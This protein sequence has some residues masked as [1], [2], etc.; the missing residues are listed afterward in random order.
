MRHA[1]FTELPDPIRATLLESFPALHEHAATAEVLWLAREDFP[2]VRL[3]D[4]A[5]QRVRVILSS[6]AWRFCHGQEEQEIQ[7]FEPV[8]VLR[9]EPPPAVAP[10]RRRARVRSLARA[11]LSLV[12]AGLIG[13]GLGLLTPRSWS[14]L[15]ATQRF[16]ELWQDEA[17]LLQLLERTPAAS[18]GELWELAAHHPSTRVREVAE[19]LRR[20]RRDR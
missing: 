17:A 19:R 5:G 3:E 6:R 20:Q 9:R 1:P 16:H 8:L 10:N 11:V 15:E 2:R 4:V 7:P 14:T 18:A 12:V 13:L